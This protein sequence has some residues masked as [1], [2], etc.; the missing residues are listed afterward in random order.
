MTKVNE[1]YT[2]TARNI[3]ELAMVTDGMIERF[4][5]FNEAKEYG[6][7]LENEVQLKGIE[8]INVNEVY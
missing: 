7:R 3:C 5:T 6:K 8:V 2:V 1:Y 4:K